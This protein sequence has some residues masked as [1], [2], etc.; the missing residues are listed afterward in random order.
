MMPST[1]GKRLAQSRSLRSLFLSSRM[2]TRLL[3]SALMHLRLPLSLQSS[4][5]FKPMLTATCLLLYVLHIFLCICTVSNHTL[6]QK[7]TPSSGALAEQYNRADGTPLSAVDLTWSYAAFLTAYN[8]RANV[9]PASWGAAS[10]SSH[11][12]AKRYTSL[13]N[14]SGQ[15]AQLL[16]QRLCHRSLRRSHKHQLEQPRLALHS[17]RYRNRRL[18]R[19]PHRHRHNLQRAKD[20]RLW[21]N[22][23]HL[24]QHSL[25]RKLECGKRSRSVCFWIHQLQP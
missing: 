17:H 7:Y 13:T 16:L 6:Q 19:N 5:L 12:H 4:T 1:S 20:H 8:A 3:P 22:H 9:I 24:R 23:L 21:R 11:H 15:T 2:S 14:Q 18:L 10:V 25:A